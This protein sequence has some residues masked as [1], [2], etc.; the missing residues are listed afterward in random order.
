MNGIDPN[1]GL[2]VSD[3]KQAAQRLKRALTTQI[4][5]RP[6]RRKVGG[7]VR[8]HHGIASEEGRMI[9]INRIHRV[10][11]NPHNH[12]ADIKNPIVQAAIAGAGYRI[13]VIYDYNGEQ[14]AIEL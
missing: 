6:K 2:S 9:I 12:L 4:G 11:A 14:G 7:E 1:T 5:S 8:K 10:I 3:S 13:R